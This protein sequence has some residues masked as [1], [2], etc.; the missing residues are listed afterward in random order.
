MN[1]VPQVCARCS[2]PLRATDSVCPFCG[3]VVNLE[4]HPDM[5]SPPPPPPSPPPPLETTP[6]QSRE[7]VDT[8]ATEPVPWERWRE[9]GFFNALWR[10]WRNS[11]FRPVEFFRKMPP[12]SGLGSAIGYTV[13]VTTL[14]LFFS[15]YWNAVEGALGGA[16]AEGGLVF[17]LIGSLVALL[18]GLA[19][20][21]PLYV[22]FLFVAV[23]VIHVGFLVVGAGRRGFEGTFRA[24]AYA[25]SPAVFAIFPFF[26]PILS[27]VWGMVLVYIGVR[28]VQR[29]TNG[30]ATLGFLVPFVAFLLFM[31]I[32]AVLFELLLSSLVSGG[33]A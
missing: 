10:T 4:Q 25:S 33:V 5:P 24:V 22:G 11:V 32:L 16:G 7:A 26:G 1:N 23:A 6:A 27:T 31:I 28:E 2:A 13:L 3:H 20:I 21:I 17:A 30:R 9:L 29:T 18:F 19:F 14:G 12:R 8:A 15:F